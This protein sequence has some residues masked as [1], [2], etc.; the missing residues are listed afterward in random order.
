MP[1]ARTILEEAFIRNPDSEEIWLAAFKVEFENAELDRARWA[2][3][4]E[5]NEVLTERTAFKRKE[6]IPGP[7]AA[8]PLV[9]RGGMG[10]GMEVLCI[11]LACFSS[12]GEC[13]CEA[14]WGRA[15][16]LLGMGPAR[17]SN[18]NSEWVQC[19]EPACSPGT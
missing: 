7:R 12:T 16:G 4:L 2:R 11:N 6:E 15:V 5:E 1:G 17:C 18:R 3:C 10:C 13:L 14:A 9:C 19:G 8:L